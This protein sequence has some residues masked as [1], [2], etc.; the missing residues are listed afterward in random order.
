MTGKGELANSICFKASL[1]IGGF[2]NAGLH[3][4]ILPRLTGFKVDTFWARQQRLVPDSKPHLPRKPHVDLG[5]F[6][7]ENLQFLM[8]DADSRI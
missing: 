6:A 4:W 5:E 2:P 3:L 8:G 1:L 7:E